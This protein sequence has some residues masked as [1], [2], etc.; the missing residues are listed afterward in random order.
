MKICYYHLNT[1]EK[2]P[3]KLEVYKMGRFKRIRVV[4][5]NLDL[6]YTCLFVQY[7]NN[8][9]HKE[10]GNEGAG[11]LHVLIILIENWSF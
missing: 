6:N 7:W 4:I 8:P 3:L 1:T 5:D 11:T 9:T 2:F 10:E